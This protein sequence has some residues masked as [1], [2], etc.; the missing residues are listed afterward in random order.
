MNFINEN[1]NIF[2]FATTILIGFLI[3]LT[4]IVIY[5]FIKISR[6]VSK[7]IEKGDF[8]MEK[9]KD[10]KIINT[11]LPTLLPILGF[12]FNAKKKKK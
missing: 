1:A 11:I 7:I 5:I 2:F 12:L 6:F 9:N 4:S 10:N 8:I 3:I